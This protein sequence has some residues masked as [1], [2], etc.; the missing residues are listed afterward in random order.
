MADPPAPV[1]RKTELRIGLLAAR[2][3]RPEAERA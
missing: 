2:A 3:A 1:D